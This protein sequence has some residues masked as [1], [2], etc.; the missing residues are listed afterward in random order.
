MQ[1]SLRL[2]ARYRWLYDSARP[3]LVID[4]FEGLQPTLGALSRD[5]EVTGRVWDTRT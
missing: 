5:Y 2:L 4:G 3:F 1:L